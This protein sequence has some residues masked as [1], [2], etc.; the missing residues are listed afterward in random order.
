MAGNAVLRSAPPNGCGTSRIWYW[1]IP[2]FE[3]FGCQ[4][5]FFLRK[6][7][8]SRGC[9]RGLN[10]GLATGDELETVL[11][12][13]D[14]AVKAAKL[15]P[16]LPVMGQ[17]VHGT[18]IAIVDRKH[19][20]KGWCHPNLAWSRT[21]GLITTARGLPLAVAIADCLPIL[22]VDEQAR[23]VGVVHA[24]WRGLMGG[25]LSQTVLKFQQ[26]LGISAERLWVAVGPGIGPEAFMVQGEVLARLRRHYPEAVRKE[27]SPNCAG[28][29]LWKAARTQ[30]ISQGIRKTQLVIIRDCTA[31]HPR[32]YFSHRRDNGRTGR[33][34][35]V[36]Q[37]NPK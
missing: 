8:I 17:Q 3:R 22:F 34:L 25:I 13:R 29:D 20:G 5:R 36:V 23:A 15:G 35:G 6:G 2:A 4:G 7:G 11:Q 9:Y 32:K 12:N 26:E 31:N 10:L 16:H 37:I 1:T 28:F 30:L 18:G 19:A 33:M 27:I 24:G 21:D 14:G